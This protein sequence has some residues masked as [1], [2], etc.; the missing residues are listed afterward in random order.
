MLAC[1][2]HNGCIDDFILFRYLGIC[3]ARVRVLAYDIFL[4][5]VDVYTG[6]G[7]FGDFDT[8]QVV[9]F[10]VLNNGSNDVVDARGGFPT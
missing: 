8:L 5:V 10:V 6:L 1:Y 2:R 7:G 9:V 4:T 3:Y